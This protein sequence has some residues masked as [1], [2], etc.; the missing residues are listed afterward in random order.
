M[1]IFSMRQR[2]FIKKKALKGKYIYL[3]IRFYKGFTPTLIRAFPE[4]GVTFLGY[5][6]VL[7]YLNK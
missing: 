5:E 6:A 3:I 4:S 7:H 1:L 2:E